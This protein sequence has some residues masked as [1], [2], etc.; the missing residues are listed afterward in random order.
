MNYCEFYTSRNFTAA[1][2]NNNEF[3]FTMHSQKDEIPTLVDRNSHIHK[4]NDKSQILLCSE[5]LAGR[6]KQFIDCSELINL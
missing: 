6:K 4:M 1:E 2:K 5:C 3:C